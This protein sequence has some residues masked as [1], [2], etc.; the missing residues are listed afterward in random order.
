MTGDAPFTGEEP[1]LGNGQPDSSWVALVAQARSGDRV[2]QRE[3]FER[4]APGVYGYLL[5]MTRDA[6]QAADLTQDTFVKALA[7]LPR[8]REPAAFAT[9][10]FRIA[11]NA[12][13]DRAARAS[14]EQLDEAVATSLPDPRGDV[15]RAVLGA[16]LAAA[17]DEAVAGLRPEHREVVV[18]HHLQGLDV[19]RAA[20][21]VGVPVGTV[22]SRLARARETLRRR[23]SPWLENA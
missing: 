6:E 15:E 22:K 2:A 1:V 7:R 10:V 19:E 14:E 9:W 11:H 4:F 12:A 17:V 20:Q 18:L 16:A 21:V 13:R 5:R 3:L 8:L 23:L